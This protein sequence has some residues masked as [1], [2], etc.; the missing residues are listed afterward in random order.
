M[1]Q[2]LGAAIWHLPGSSAAPLEDGIS[3]LPARPV[4][5]PQL[6][7]NPTLWFLDRI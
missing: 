2:F 5:A 3:G 4:P 1:F 7:S 6:L